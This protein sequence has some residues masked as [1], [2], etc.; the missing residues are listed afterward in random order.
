MGT[1]ENVGTD[2]TFT[3]FWSA[4]VKRVGN[5]PSVPGFSARQQVS[6]LRGT[7]EIAPPKAQAVLAVF[8]YDETVTHEEIPVLL[9]GEVFLS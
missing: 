5:F 8:H 6:G 2:G 9:A 4:G 1:W 3:N 7:F